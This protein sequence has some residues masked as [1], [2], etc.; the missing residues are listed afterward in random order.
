M[1]KNYLYLAIFALVAF[2]ATSCEKV[3]TEGMTRITYYPQLTLEGETYMVLDK[4]S[5][6]VEPGYSALLNG[7]DVTENVE[8]EDNIDTTTSG[9]Y[10]VTYS[11]VNADGFASTTSRT[12]VVLDPT[13]AVE[14]FYYTDPA[15]YRVASATGVYGGEFEVLIL[16]NGD[17][18]YSVDDML[19]GWYAQ[20][21]GYGMN[22]AMQGT[23][24][25][26][27]DGVISL[28]EDYVPGWGDS[29]DGMTDATFDA[30]T[31]TIKWN[32]GYA[33]MNFVVTMSKR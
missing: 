1:K 11:I 22:Y 15:S 26:A 6:Y 7:E 10:S 18:T 5:Q 21:A 33:G 23:I 20:R 14:G 13:D 32:V 24:A 3:T 8:V 17:G 2:F 31:K 12:V 19:A 27:E 9:V 30:E 25:V 29:S 28:L 4:G 16:N